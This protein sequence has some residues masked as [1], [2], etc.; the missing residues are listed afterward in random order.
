MRPI[1]YNTLQAGRVARVHGKWIGF[2]NSGGGWDT[3][4]ARFVNDG[5]A[6]DWSA[7]PMRFHAPQFATGTAV[8]EANN[9]FDIF[10]RAAITTPAMVFEVTPE[11]VQPVAGRIDENNPSQ[12]WYDDAWGPG[13]SLRYTV[14]HGR[15]P[16]VTREAVIDPQLCPQGRDLRASWLVRSPRALTLIGGRRPQNPDGSDWTGAPGDTA[17][18]P[19]TGA[20]IHYFDGQVDPV[21]GAGFK[22]PQIWYW[23]N[24]D[25]ITGLGT[26]VSLPATVTATIVS[27]D[28]IRLTKTIPAALVAAARLAGSLLITDDV[29]TIYPDPNVETTTC[30]GYVQYMQEDEFLEWD[31][32]LIV[33]QGN[34]NNTDGASNGTSIDYLSE[35]GDSY[36]YTLNKR[37][38]ESYDLSAL[39]G[40]T[41]T[42]AALNRTLLVAAT[43]FPASPAAVLVSPTLDSYTSLSEE[44]DY[45]LSDWNN[46]AELASR[47]EYSSLSPG[48]WSL[49]LNAAGVSYLQGRLGSVAAFGILSSNEFDGTDPE[50]SGHDEVSAALTW[51]SADA[52]GTSN[53]P[54]LEV[55]Y[56]AAGGGDPGATRRQMLRMINSCDSKG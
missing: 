18:I 37:A 24:I 43:S 35:P 46:R 32:F 47:T 55:T 21:R 16:R 25:P 17:E 2:R 5:S 50:I 41:V 26:L 54:Y 45:V 14:W 38:A 8:L 1:A 7:G 9:R 6:F 11:N 15:A 13:L 30:D 40:N 34:Y 51:Y 12:I 36:G 56:E 33:S 44:E 53:D 3:V 49:S 27:T 29:Q 4:D 10:S 31:E 20:A 52:S 19:P 22:P 48:A 28:T 23:D 42:A 39:S